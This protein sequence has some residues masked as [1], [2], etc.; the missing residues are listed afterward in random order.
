MACAVCAKVLEATTYEGR[1]LGYDHGRYLPAKPDHVA[2][3]VPQEQLHVNGVC[4]FCGNPDPTH[5]VPATT[6]TYNVAAEYDDGTIVDIGEP[7]MNMEGDWSAC[8][9]CAGYIDRDQWDVMARY[10]V[11]QS[12][13]RRDMDPATLAWYKD[14]VVRSLL[15][16][17]WALLRQHI[18]GPPEPFTWPAPVRPLTP[19]PPD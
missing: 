6:F 14:V 12:M 18:T 3:P 17:Q 5:R 10:S 4:D 8:T 7:T 1:L 16:G 9:R 15:E 19:P 11:R 2:V 13:A